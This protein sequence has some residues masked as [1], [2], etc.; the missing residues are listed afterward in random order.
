MVELWTVIVAPVV[1]HRPCLFNPS[2][3]ILMFV[4]LSREREEKRRE[5]KEKRDLP[6]LLWDDCN[7]MH[8]FKG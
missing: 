8:D 3:N 6:V 4:C 2:H 1:I 5:E 7:S